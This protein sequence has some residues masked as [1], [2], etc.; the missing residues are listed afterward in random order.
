VRLVFRNADLRHHLGLLHTRLEHV[1]L[2]LPPQVRER[3]PFLFERLLE[4][5]VG[6]DV[7]VLLDVV[8]DALE[9]FVG[10]DVAELAAT[11]DEQELVDGAENQLRRA[12][13]N[14]FLQFGAVGGNVLKLGTLPQKFDL[15]ALEIALGDDVPV[16]L[17]QDLLDN[18]GADNPGDI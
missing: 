8:E 3:H 6:V 9:L 14:C 18:L 5:F 13:R 1:L 12:F 17:D 7:V 10:H 11:L 16:H 2:E 15:H 4:L